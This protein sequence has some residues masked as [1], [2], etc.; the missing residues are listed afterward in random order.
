MH[1]V[2][3]KHNVHVQVI[4]GSLEEYKP[5]EEIKEIQAKVAAL[6]EKARKF[7]EEEFDPEVQAIEESVKNINEEHQKQFKDKAEGK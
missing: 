2:F 3:D 6:S 5:T 4:C 7:M 1:I